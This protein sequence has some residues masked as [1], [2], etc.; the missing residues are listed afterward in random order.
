M[1]RDKTKKSLK[2]AMKKLGSA[3]KRKVS[4]MSPG[5]RRAITGSATGKTT[6]EKLMKALKKSFLKHVLIFIG[7][8]IKIFLLKK[9]LIKYLK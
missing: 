9:T 4:G 7:K 8:I 1:D 2:E 3:P 6:R 5:K